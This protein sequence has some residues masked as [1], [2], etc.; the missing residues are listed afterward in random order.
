[1]RAAVMS[2][3]IASTLLAVAAASA[4][5]EAPAMT[6]GDLHQLCLGADHVSRNA[7]RIYILGVT[8]GLQV[9]LDI[10]DGR[11]HAARPCVPGDT[12]AEALE[13]L[14]KR[15]LSEDL[16]ASPRAGERDAA[17]FVGGALGH[18]FPCGKHA[19]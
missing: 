16:A 17:R 10:A 11:L 6:A 5:Q 15:K 13:T 7:C 9:G 1:M 14:L 2:A 12:S 18:A 4:L 8:Q 3:S 19:P